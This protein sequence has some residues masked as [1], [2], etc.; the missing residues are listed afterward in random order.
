MQIRSTN[1]KINFT[2]NFVKI[3]FDEKSCKKKEK[4]ALAKHF[5]VEQ[6][7]GLYTK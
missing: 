2:K 3:I 6:A 5:R 7:V 1:V 4:H